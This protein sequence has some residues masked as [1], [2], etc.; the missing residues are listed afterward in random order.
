MLFIE[1]SKVAPYND[2]YRQPTP[3]HPQEPQTPK[4]LI[5]V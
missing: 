2:Q 1:A 3:G 5:L 4:P